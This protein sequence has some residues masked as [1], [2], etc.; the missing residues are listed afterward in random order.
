[1]T[2]ATYK[3]AQ[4]Q[5]QF[6]G[7]KRKFCTIRCRDIKTNERHRAERE[8]DGRGR[9]DAACNQTHECLACGVS[10]KPKRAGRVKACSRECGWK[11]SGKI[12]Q[13]RHNGGRVWVTMHRN[14]PVIIKRDRADHPPLPKRCVQCQAGFYPIKNYQRSCSE[15]CV[16]AGKTKSRRIR[17]S[18]ERA[19]LRGA[20]VEF[21]DPIKVFDRDAWRCQICLKKVSKKNRGS[22]KPNAPELDHI[23]PLSKGGEHSYANTQC[24]CRK[25]NNFKSDRPYGQ[26]PLFSMT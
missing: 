24:T 15:D 22:T 1:M 18:A 23:L 21:V 4:C 20:T 12:Q 11:I 6:A 25:C 17:R 14:A 26:I 5:G 16:V 13:V 8:A 7:R 9:A 2:A 19:R 10:F 3:C